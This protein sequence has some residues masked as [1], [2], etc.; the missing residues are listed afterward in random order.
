[1]SQVIVDAV[2]T[3]RDR[4]SRDA[5]VEASLD[6]QRAT[7]DEPGC[8]AYCFAA[9]PIVDDRVQVFELWESEQALDDHL[10]HDNYKAMFKLIVGS[11]IVSAPSNKYLIERSAP[12]YVGR[13]PTGFFES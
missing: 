5:V 7:R 8:L 2:V 3:M 11:G 12:V 10:R 6:L 1:M 13:T 9:D 4:A